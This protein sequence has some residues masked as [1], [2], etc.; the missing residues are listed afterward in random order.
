MAE[1]KVFVEQVKGDGI[2]K[3]NIILKNEHADFTFSDVNNSYFKEH[4]NF[5]TSIIQNYGHIIHFNDTHSFWFNQGKL[6]IKITNANLGCLLSFKIDKNI[7]DAFV[8]YEN[9]PIKPVACYYDHNKN[10]VCINNDGDKF[11]LVNFRHIAN[12]IWTEFENGESS[13]KLISDSGK[14]KWISYDPIY[15]LMIHDAGESNKKY[16]GAFAI[17]EFEYIC[18]HHS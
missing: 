8:S 13:F 1:T 7:Y 10:N 18:K 14:K 12:T 16:F 17:D 15:G 9:G 4:P 5:F 2:T 11:N 6:M 3:N